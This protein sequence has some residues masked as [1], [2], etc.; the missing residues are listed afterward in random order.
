MRTNPLIV[1]GTLE[2]AGAFSDRKEAH[3]L[4]RHLNAPISVSVDE[5][6]RECLDAATA[7]RAI[8]ELA[9]GASDTL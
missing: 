4:V 2:L 7:H 9:I 1:V 5:D 8:E 6:K 3:D